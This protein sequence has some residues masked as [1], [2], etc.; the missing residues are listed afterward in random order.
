M[1]I[2]D[3]LA[4]K[5]ENVADAEE[6]TKM[7]QTLPPSFDALVMESSLSEHT[8]DQIV[9][10][11]LANIERRTKIGTWPKNKHEN[12]MTAPIASYS[13]LDVQLSQQSSFGKR[14]QGRVRGKY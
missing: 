8:F 11:A 14:H 12:S 6:V 9:N 13:R 2:L 1:S 5:D 4:A 3:E 10:A 7:L